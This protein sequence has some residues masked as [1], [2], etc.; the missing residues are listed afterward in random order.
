MSTLRWHPI[1]P[2]Q[3]LDYPNAELIFTAASPHSLSETLEKTTEDHAKMDYKD[4]GHAEHEGKEIADDMRKIAEMEGVEHGY[5]LEN[6]HEQEDVQGGVVDW[7][8][9]MLRGKG[10]VAGG[11]ESLIHGHWE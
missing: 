3:Y 5:D 6:E 1:D 9:G 4:E 8:M 2:P 11:E 10:T 7:V